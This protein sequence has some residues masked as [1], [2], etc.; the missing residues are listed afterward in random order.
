MFFNKKYK[1]RI[2][3]LERSNICLRNEVNNLTRIV[4]DRDATLVITRSHLDDAQKE[5]QFLKRPI[6]VE[7]KPVK[8][9]T[10]KLKIK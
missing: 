9:I 5:L 6:V 1:V 4:Q 8:K 10:K 7:K 3:E 2:A